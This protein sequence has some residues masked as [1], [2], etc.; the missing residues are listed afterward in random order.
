MTVESWKSRHR[1]NRVLGKLFLHALPPFG[2]AVQM[3]QTL[4]GKKA[5]SAV[6]GSGKR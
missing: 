6:G 2:S 3:M 4:E 1:P 5:L